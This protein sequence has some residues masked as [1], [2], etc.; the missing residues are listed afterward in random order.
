MTKTIDY[1]FSIGSPWAFIGLEP[2]AVL[3]KEQGA[4]IR[5]HVIPL[6]EENGGIYSRNR[7][8]ARRAYWIRDLKRWAAL[9]G[10]VLNF[11]NRAALSDPAPAGLMVAA[12]IE[13]GD[14]W[15]KLAAALQEAFWVRGEDIGNADVRR[16][17]A[18]A[19]GFDAAALDKHG[20]SDAVA[21]LQKVSFEAAREAGVFGVPTY[22]YQDELYWGQD[23]L[24]F[25]ERH[26]R[27]EKLAA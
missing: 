20:Q 17:I 10:K 19:A 26:L 3:A 9:R 13:T 2:F 27:G 8:E 5:P 12:A 4:T 11:D 18:T 16:A 25:L 24:P 14:D 22:R 21:A 1:F 7:P 23:S 6:I 15:L